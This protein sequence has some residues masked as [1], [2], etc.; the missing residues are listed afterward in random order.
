MPYDY[1][2]YLKEQKESDEYLETTELVRQ[3]LWSETVNFRMS[4]VWL[5]IDERILIMLHRTLR[6]S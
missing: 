1:C 2:E 5:G 6:N 4:Q 3:K